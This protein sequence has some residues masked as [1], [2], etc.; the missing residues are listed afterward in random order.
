[1]LILFDMHILESFSIGESVLII[2]FWASYI[3]PNLSA[4]PRPSQATSFAA[5]PQNLRSL[6]VLHA[7]LC[8][9]HRPDP[10]GQAAPAKGGSWR[11]VLY[12]AW[13]G[14]VFFIVSNNFYMKLLSWSVA[15]SKEKQRKQ[16]REQSMMNLVV[17]EWLIAGSLDLAPALRSFHHAPPVWPLT[18]QTSPDRYLMRHV[19]YFMRSMRLNAYRQGVCR[20]SMALPCWDAALVWALNFPY[21]VS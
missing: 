1:M 18:A 14:H 19:K 17:Y 3:V 8:E 2:H 15:G 13:K 11:C 7:I 6:Q 4:I 12:G 16:A 9:G 21:R 5:G 10:S 20:S